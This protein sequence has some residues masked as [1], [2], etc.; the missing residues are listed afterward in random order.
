[1]T[2]ISKIILFNTDPFILFGKKESNT[3]SET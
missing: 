3:N 2:K 1:M